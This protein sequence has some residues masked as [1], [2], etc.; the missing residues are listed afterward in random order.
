[1]S[2]SKQG[3]ENCDVVSGKR[4]CGRRHHKLLHGQQLVATPQQ[5]SN[6]SLSGLAS[7][8]LA[9]PLKETLLQTALARLTVNGQEMAVRVLLDSGRQRSYVRK[10][11]AESLGLQ[12]PSE[13]LGT[14]RS[15][16]RRLL[17]R[18]G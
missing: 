13:L 5:P 2:E 17:E 9:L 10:N 15:G 1:M 7:A 11:I 6:I 3:P 12:G 4:Y 8:K 14:L 18:G 16:T